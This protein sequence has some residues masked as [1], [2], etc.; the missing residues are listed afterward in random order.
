MTQSILTQ[1]QALYAESEV[2]KAFFEILAKRTNDAKQTRVNRMAQL[3]ELADV[4]VTTREIVRIMKRLEELGL[5]RYIPGRH[6]SPSR[7]E[8]S[9]S[10]LAAAKAAIGQS[11]D[12]DLSLPPG[13]EASDEDESEQD[14]LE[15]RFHLRPELQV[16]IEL[17]V[18]F[19]PQEAERL[20]AFIRALPITRE[21]ASK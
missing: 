18:D 19:S 16:V 11:S 3:I 17:P 15:H 10:A 7:F 12:L 20:A 13:P 4:A 6:S 5:G 1:L 9:T 21:E 2:T 8:W 14:S